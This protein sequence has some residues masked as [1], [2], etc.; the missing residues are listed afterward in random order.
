MTN[1]FHDGFVT[2]RQ[3][4]CKELT[5]RNALKSIL[6]Q[7]G[8]KPPA[9]SVSPERKIAWPSSLAAALFR[10]QTFHDAR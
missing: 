2:V 7:W 8:A 4:A 5:E 1:L 6:F 9:F 3:T 10:P